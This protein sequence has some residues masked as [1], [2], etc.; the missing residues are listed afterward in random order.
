M[1]YSNGKHVYLCCFKVEASVRKP[2]IEK[3]N[4]QVKVPEL[5]HH[6]HFLNFGNCSVVFK[7]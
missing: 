2:E 4:V 5:L 3:A 1:A 6:Y 7:M